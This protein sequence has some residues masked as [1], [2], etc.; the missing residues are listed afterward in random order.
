MKIFYS[1]VLTAATWALL[2]FDMPKG[3]FKAG[4]EPDK[5]EMGVDPGAGMNLTKAA[6]IQ[7]NTDKIKGFGTL[8][9]NFMP[10]KYIGKKIRMTGFMKSKDVDVWAGFWLRVDGDVSAAAANI[11]CM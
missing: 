3:W 6:T 11:N 8:M 9:Q 5:Y 7:S 4:S 2:S 10:D 1:L